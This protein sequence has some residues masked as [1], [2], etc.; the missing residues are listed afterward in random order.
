MAQNELSKVNSRV[1]Q[2]WIAFNFSVCFV[3]DHQLSLSLLLNRLLVYIVSVSHPGA[4]GSSLETPARV[5]SI[6]VT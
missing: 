2:Y 4:Y 1:F 6:G 5:G 3:I